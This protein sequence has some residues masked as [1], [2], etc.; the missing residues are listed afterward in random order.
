VG[1]TLNAKK[2][3][4]MIAVDEG[5]RFKPYK[6][7][8]GKLTI[9][10]GHNLDDLGISQRVADL[11][12]KEDAEI[13]DIACYKIFGEQYESWSENRRLGWLNLAF[14]LGHG[15][16]LQFR[17][18]IRAARIEDWP[19]VEKGLRASLWFKQVGKRAERVIKMVCYEKFPY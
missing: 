15:R 8:A 7:T 13:A 3:Q 19:E 4:K 1:V 11:L 6:C 2:L 9:G 14:N 12:L 17:N 10:Y 5:L 18:T 16:L